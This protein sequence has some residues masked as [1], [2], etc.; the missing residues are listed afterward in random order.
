MFDITVVCV[1]V[2]LSTVFVADLRTLS[3]TRIMQ[4]Q[5]EIFTWRL[6]ASIRASPLLL[7]VAKLKLYDCCTAVWCIACEYRN[8]QT[9][10]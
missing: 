3:I 7:T 1:F 2:Y 6:D 10:K 5:V 8:I 4:H 9:R